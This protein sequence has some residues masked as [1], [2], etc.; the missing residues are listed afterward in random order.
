MPES[1]VLPHNIEAEAAVLGACL[2]GEKAVFETISR[3]GAED[4]YDPKYKRI[5]ESILNLTEKNMPVDMVSLSDEL[6]NEKALES[7][8]GLEVISN[9]T[10]FLPSTENTYSYI[11]IIK[12]KSCL[13]KLIEKSRENIE[14]AFDKKN[15]DIKEVIDHAESRIFEISQDNNRRSYTKIGEVTKEVNAEA[16]RMFDEGITTLG[17]KTGYADLDKLISGLQKQDMI[18][19]AARPSMGK[20]AFA[21][22]L[23]LNIAKTNPNAVIAF[24]SHEM[25]NKQIGQRILSNLSFVPLKNIQDASYYGKENERDKIFGAYNELSK[26][27]LFLDDS[28]GVTT[29]DIR[30]KARRIKKENKRLDLIVIDYLQLLSLGKK[31]ENRQQETSEISRNIKSL[32]KE[33]NCPVVILSQLSRKNEERRDRRPILSDLRDSGAIE[34]DADQVLFLHR[35]GRYNKDAEDPNLAELIIE[36]NRNGATGVV[37]LTW[38]GEFTRFDSRAGEEKE[39]DKQREEINKKYEKHIS[40][41]S[42]KK[43]N[44][45]ENG[46]TMP[47]FF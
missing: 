43:E 24:F 26:T 23:T 5:F 44:G 3:L 27:N 13:K 22:C 18:V 16:K 40:K 20:T 32:A 11:R 36:K 9:L 25:S 39:R 2:L 46:E 33:L 12:E 41:T 28:S 15:M 35:E 37:H 8:G 7:I 31:I 6:K 10:S 34:Q 42:I 4:F 38:K 19:I 17:I 45:K 29:M 1:R 47:S 21:I 14:E 30:G